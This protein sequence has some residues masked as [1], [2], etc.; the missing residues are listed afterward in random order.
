MLSQMKRNDLRKE[1]SKKGK[2]EERETTRER[3]QEGNRET[4]RES[5]ALMPNTLASMEELAAR[6]LLS[7]RW[8]YRF[9]AHSQHISVPNGRWIGFLGKVERRL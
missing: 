3:K 2:K 8:R 1:Q 6:G 5:T 7:F 4:G 9:W